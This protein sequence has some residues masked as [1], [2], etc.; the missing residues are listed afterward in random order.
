[1]GEGG[2]WGVGARACGAWGPQRGQ[3]ELVEPQ[4]EE[5]ESGEESRVTVVLA[6]YRAPTVCPAQVVVFVPETWASGE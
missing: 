5:C 6:D 4:G 3:R 2:R 1:M